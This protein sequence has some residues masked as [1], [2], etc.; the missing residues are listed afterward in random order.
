MQNKKSKR[1]E[2]I[3]MVDKNGIDKKGI[4]QNRFWTIFSFEI[5][6]IKRKSRMKVK[7]TIIDIISLENEKIKNK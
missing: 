2:Q 4:V 5:M 1:D 3:E 7:K 6:M